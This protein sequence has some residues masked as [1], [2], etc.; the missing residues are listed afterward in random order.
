M[1]IHVYPNIQSV[2]TIQGGAGFLPVHSIMKSCNISINLWQT[3]IL[4]KVGNGKRNG[5]T[6]KVKPVTPLISGPQRPYLFIKPRKGKWT[7]VMHPYQNGQLDIIIYNQLYIYIIYT[8]LK[9][10]NIYICIYIYI[11]IYINYIIYIYILYIT[12]NHNPYRHSSQLGGTS[13]QPS[14]RSQ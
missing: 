7:H 2:S 1:F 6:P 10:H 14:P 13:P 9:Y 12:G 8:L 4:S 5:K 3:Q 11:Y